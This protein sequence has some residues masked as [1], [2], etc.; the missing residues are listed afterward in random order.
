MIGKKQDQTVGDS[1]L[2]VQATGDVTINQS[3]SPGQMLEVFNAVAKQ[4][5]AFTDAAQ[6]TMDERLNEFRSETLERMSRDTKARAEAF[7]D[8]DFQHTLFDAQ[9]S[10]ARS[11]DKGLHETLVGLIVER[12]KQKDRTRLSLSLNDAISKAGRLTT[13]E[14]AAL[15][16]IFYVKHVQHGNIHTVEQLSQ[17]LSR[18]LSGVIDDVPVEPAAYSYMDSLGC[19]NVGNNIISH[20]DFFQMLQ[21]R[22]PW[23]VTRGTDETELLEVFPRAAYQG[24]IGS[25]VVDPSKKVF[26]IADPVQLSMTGTFSGLGAD[27]GARYLEICKKNVPSKEE[28][29]TALRNTGFPAIDTMVAKY[30]LTP[31]KNATLTSAGIA[32]GHAYLVKKGELN[33]DLSI[34]IK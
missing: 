27:A 10:Y 15:G 24:L 20:H 7:A 18:I 6:K 25:S 12:S 2:A 33:A 8:P 28:F 3:M 1:S 26:R 22:Y 21:E 16:M 9:T 11:D 19:L 32:L 5:E 17:T 34:W 4:V 14:F 23:I 30:D 29:F 31:C 13:E